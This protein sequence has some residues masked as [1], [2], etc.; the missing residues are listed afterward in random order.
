MGSVCLGVPAEQ[1]A[2][3]GDFY[4]SMG[5]FWPGQRAGHCE[6]LS[7]ACAG[8]GPGQGGAGM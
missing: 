3:P 1:S 5:S 4:R 2:F 7:Q 8:E 6:L